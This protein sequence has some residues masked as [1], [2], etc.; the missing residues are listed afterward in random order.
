MAVPVVKA[1]IVLVHGLLGF[2]EIKV[3][4]RTLASY[5]PGIVESLRAAGNR[6][7]VARL[8]KTRGV[9]DRA[10]ELK[11]FINR[12][13]SDEPVHIMAHSMGGLDA[14]YMVSRLGM[15][16]R[17]LSVTTIGTPHRG[18]SFADWGVQHLERLLRPLFD[19]FGIPGQAF[20]DLTT[21]SCRVFNDEVPDVPG[22][23]YF[24][25]AGRHLQ[26]WRSLRW[27]LLHD[28]VEKAEGPNDGVVSLASA[29]YGEDCEVWDGDHLNL[30]NWPDPAAVAGGWWQDRTPRYA[31]LVCRLADIGF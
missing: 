5:F 18:T 7:L 31:G 3:C 8:S 23:R 13:A 20:Y 16:S 30:V 17:V 9:A 4:G 11:R 12:F 19:L 25:V 21:R 28:I 1:P 15:A 26:T 27:K 24:S 22:V 10:A 29:T 14:R 2:D 6:V